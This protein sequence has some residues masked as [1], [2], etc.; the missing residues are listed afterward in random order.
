MQ[1]F[2][3]TEYFDIVAKVLLHKKMIRVRLAPL[4]VTSFLFNIRI[5]VNFPW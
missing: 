1:D 5:E 4:N 3:L 2:Y